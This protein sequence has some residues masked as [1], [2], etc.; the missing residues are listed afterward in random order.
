MAITVPGGSP[1]IKRD[2]RRGVLVWLGAF[3]QFLGVHLSTVG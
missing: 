1:C 2:A 3:A